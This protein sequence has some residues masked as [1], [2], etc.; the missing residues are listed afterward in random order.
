MPTKLKALLIQRAIISNKFYIDQAI[1]MKFCI[2]T[3]YILI[4]ILLKFQ[5]SFYNINAVTGKRTQMFNH[6]LPL[7]AIIEPLLQIKNF[8]LFTD[9]SRFTASSRA[10]T[11]SNHYLSNFPSYPHKNVLIKCSSTWK[12][13]L[14]IV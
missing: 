3:A 14:K 1:T 6:L 11:C 10:S 7:D 12:C 4:I 13:Y 5:I 2:N 8:Q 9:F